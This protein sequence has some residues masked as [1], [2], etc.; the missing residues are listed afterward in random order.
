VQVGR[1]ATGSAPRSRIEA[2]LP[3]LEQTP[4]REQRAHDAGGVATVPD[5]QQVAEPTPSGTGAEVA[6][7]LD[8]LDS[9]LELAAVTSTPITAPAAPAVEEAPKQRVELVESS[10]REPTNEQA[11]PRRPHPAPQLVSRVRLPRGVLY[12]L[13]VGVAGSFA[14][15]SSSSLY[16][17]AVAAL[18]AS[19]T[20]IVVELVL[21][22]VNP[23]IARHLGL[24]RPETRV[25]LYTAGALLAVMTGVAVSYIV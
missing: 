19:A 8:F 1:G 18:A 24:A 11:I 25:M 12:W 10:P 21:R 9:C 7:A 20:V 4:E 16:D 23:R 5:R 13:A 3:S 15:R 22:T 14:W 6:R 17:A 2:Y